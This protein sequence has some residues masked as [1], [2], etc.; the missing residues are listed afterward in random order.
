MTTYCHCPYE[1]ASL[2]VAEGE[3]RG[4]LVCAVCQ[5]PKSRCVPDTLLA[6]PDAAAA[7][8]LPESILRGLVASGSIVPSIRRGSIVRL[9]PSHVRSQLSQKG[10]RK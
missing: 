5:R 10:I 2:Q 1:T 6:Y 8:G 9:L 4:V 3:L 7:L